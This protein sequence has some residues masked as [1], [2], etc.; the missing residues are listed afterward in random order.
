MV[1][2]RLRRL[3]PRHHVGSVVVL[4]DVV[5]RS[6]WGVP[7]N[8]PDMVMGISGELMILRPED[9]LVV[10]APGMTQELANHFDANL[11]ERLGTGRCI[12]LSDMFEV[13]IIPQGSKVVV[14]LP[15]L[16]EQIEAHLRPHLSR[17]LGE[18]GFILLPL[19]AEVSVEGDVS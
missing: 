2:L 16:T 17:A 9:K 3:P 1:L 6:S 14:R 4:H 13:M 18:D 7:V 8:E 11:T 19:E 5:G 15:G 12:L 10:R